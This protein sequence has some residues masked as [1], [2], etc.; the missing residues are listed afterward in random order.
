MNKITCNVI[1][2]MLPLYKEGLLSEDSKAIVEEHLKECPRC[3]NYLKELSAP[4]DSIADS[5]ENTSNNLALDK[6][7]LLAIRKKLLYKKYITIAASV[8]LAV[9]FMLIAYVHLS[10]PI[11]LPYSEELITFDKMD[12]GALLVTLSPEVT[13]YELNP[14]RVGSDKENVAT[15]YQ[16]FLWTT[17]LREYFPKNQEE[18]FIINK[19][20][21]NSYIPVRGVFYQGP[22]TGEMSYGAQ[23]IYG[24]GF[25]DGGGMS[26]LPRLALNMYFA[27]ALS[28]ALVGSVITLI[29]RRHPK[30]RAI[31]LRIT[32]LPI[33]YVIGSLLVK[34]TSG[35]SHT[36]IKDLTSILLLMFP[37]Y[38]L[39][40]LL[41]KLIEYRKLKE[42]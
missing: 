12:S 30:A 15:Y 5:P 8:V 19:S 1:E 9:I 13:S 34:G 39:I 31:A 7:P 42:K 11:L 41:L 22:E 37:I 3:E 27:L 14:F 18:S 6:A 2:D 25:A 33:T 20:E 36:M 21:D 24:S 28:L 17:R 29:L 16:I 26:V 40:L 32:L 35:S 23:L 4:L 38:F 10:A